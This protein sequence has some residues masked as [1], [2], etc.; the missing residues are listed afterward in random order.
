MS[1]SLEDYLR[2]IYSLKV[3]RGIVRST[4]IAD[5]LKVS[6]AAV[7]IAIK[8]MA[9]DQYIEMN[10]EK[11]ILL[12]PR[13]EEIAKEMYYRHDLMRAYLI[14]LGVSEDEADESACGIEHCMSTEAFRRMGEHILEE[15][16]DDIAP[17]R[18]AK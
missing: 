2:T 1:R 3:Q 12:L 18:K 13:G 17:F 7:S 14:H 9:E 4:D 10:K 15:H 16:G 11:H 6:K 8:K 5:R